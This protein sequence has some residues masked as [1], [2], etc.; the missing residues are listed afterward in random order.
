MVLWHNRYYKISENDRTIKYAG[1][2]FD[3][4]VHEIFPQLIAGAEIHVI[5]S[6]IRME[7][8]IRDRL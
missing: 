4:S 2:G 6:E 8:C 1:F 7:M 3:A 5:P